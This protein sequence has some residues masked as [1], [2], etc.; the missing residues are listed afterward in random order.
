MATTKIEAGQPFPTLIVPKLGGGELDLSKPENGKDWRMVVVY[1]GKHCP[2][3]TRYLQT[4][5]QLLPDFHK[6]GV[7][8][9]AVSSDP[10]DKAQSQIDGINPNF[11]VGYDLTVD[12]MRKL[13]L[14]I[15]HPWSA[16]ETDRPFAEPGLF[17]INAEGNVQVVDI[18]NVPFGRPDLNSVLMGLNFIR[19]PDNNYPIRGTH[20]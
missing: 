2:L 17:V 19:N 15:S 16:N 9:V 6:I 14:Y 20:Q 18:S 7:D 3:C 13:G 1:R 8:V 4:L 5:N 12:Q 11:P 10:Q